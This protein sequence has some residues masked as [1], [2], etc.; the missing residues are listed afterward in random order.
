MKFFV[1]SLFLIFSL[2]VLGSDKKI[3]EYMAKHQLQSFVKNT[4]DLKNQKYV[5]LVKAVSAEM[6]KKR[7]E[8]CVGGGSPLLYVNSD[9]CSMICVDNG[10]SELRTKALLLTKGMIDLNKETRDCQ[11]LCHH[12]QDVTFAFQDGLKTVS[13]SSQD[14]HD[15]VVDSERGNAK[16]DIVDSLIKSKRESSGSQQ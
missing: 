6:E 8:I 9:F 15:M 5:K 3:C 14:C 4:I 16:S 13:D 10:S 1:A 2:T 11:R 7:N 12:Y